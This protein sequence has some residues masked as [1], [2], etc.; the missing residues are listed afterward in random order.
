MDHYDLV[1]LESFLREFKPDVFIDLRSERM[2]QSLLEPDERLH[3]AV[4][5]IK[6]AKAAGL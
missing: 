2:V 3:N 1:G 4:T 6:Q 5:A